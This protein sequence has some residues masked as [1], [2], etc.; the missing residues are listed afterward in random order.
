MRVL[1]IGGTGFISTAVS[2]LAIGE[3]FQI[4]SDEVLNWDQIYGTIAEALGVEANMVHIPSD[5]IAR[6]GTAPD[7]NV[8]GGQD[9]GR[10][11]GQRQDPF[12]CAGVRMQD[13]LP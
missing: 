2:R 13:P 10:C 8:V 9:L 6:N 5:S 4:T 3:A 7:R 12:V 11:V 1:F